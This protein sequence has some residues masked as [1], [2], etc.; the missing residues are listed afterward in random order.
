M[1]LVVNARDAMPTGGRIIVETSN[2]DLDRTYASEHVTVKPGR[3]VM[4][5][6]R[7]RGRG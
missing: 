4:L 3:Y 5:Q 7:T 1:N 6:F 2:V